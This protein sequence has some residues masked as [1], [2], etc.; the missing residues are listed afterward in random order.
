MPGIYK[1][2]WSRE[3]QKYVSTAEMGTF[4]DG[5]P[6]YSKYVSAV[7]DEHQVIHLSVMNVMPD[8]LTNNTTYPIA[9]QDLPIEDIPITLNKH[10]TKA[11]PITDDELYAASPDKMKNVV[12]RHGKA[13]TIRKISM[14]AHALGPSGPTDDMPVLFATGPDDGTGRKRLTWEDIE[15]LKREFDTREW[16]E[17]GRRIT[18]SAEHEN[19]L[20]KIDK[21]FKAAFYNRATGKPYNQLG[22]DF[23]SY[24]QNPY[25]DVATK[26]KLSYG[27]EPVTH[28]RGT[29]AFIEDYTAKVDGWMKAYL[30]KAGTDPLYQRNLYN[31]R[32]H[33]IVLPTQELYRGAIVSPN[34]E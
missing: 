22:F 17:S 1:E 4:L 27:G 33:Y 31:V 3:M 26:A 10:Q 30:S 32:H 14:G 12:L 5:L 34:A 16:Q 25:Y 15:D 18:L 6:D 8:L 9:V 13:V 23:Y 7:G 2:A 20:I 19:D 11:T 24:V 29:I 28:R 21:D